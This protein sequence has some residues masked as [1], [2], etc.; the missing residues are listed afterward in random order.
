MSDTPGDTYEVK[1]WDE[2]PYDEIGKDAK[3]TRASVVYTFKGV[4]EGEGH[5]EY[6]MAYP[7][8][9]TVTY[10]GLLRV[11]GQV[12]GRAG[13]F[14]AQV[15]GIFA[16]GIPQETWTIVPG[17]GTGDLQ[18]IQG[19]GRTEAIDGQNVV[20]YTFDYDVAPPQ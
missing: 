12:R 20:N 9:P 6:L 5:V 10:V 18:S 1:A 8:T 14:V 7:G 2:Q 19:Q 11:I 15:S 16:D 13:S 17:S 4:I 3:L